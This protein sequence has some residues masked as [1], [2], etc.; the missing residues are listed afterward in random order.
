MS[1]TDYKSLII[2]LFLHDPDCYNRAVPV[3]L[4]RLRANLSTQE[5]EEILK[6]V[7]DN[8]ENRDVELRYEFNLLLM[9][10]QIA[11]GLRDYKTMSA[12]GA[13]CELILLKVKIPQMPS[14]QPSQDESEFWSW[15]ETLPKSIQRTVWERAGEPMKFSC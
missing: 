3:L 7:Q 4:K 11:E 8:L 6:A 13:A 2:S 10:N 9:E 5:V 15:F 1:Q 12:M 14:D